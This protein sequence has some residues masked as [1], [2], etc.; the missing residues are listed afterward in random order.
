M[1]TVTVKFTER[2]NSGYSQKTYDYLV[3]DSVEV[4]AGDYAV[5]HNGSEFAIVRVQEVKAGASA[6]ATKTLVTILNESVLMDYKNMNEKVKE[7][8]ALFSRLE[9]LL[10]QES[11]NNKYRLLAASNAEAAKILAHLGM[12]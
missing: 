1:K 6:K 4:T 10:A 8:K 5:A 3:E 7:Q 9:Q 2:Y 12:A 11:E